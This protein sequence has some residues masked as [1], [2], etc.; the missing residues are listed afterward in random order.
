[1]IQKIRKITEDRNFNKLFETSTEIDGDQ[2]MPM[3]SCT[4]MLLYEMKSLK[5][6]QL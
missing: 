2:Q 5:E 4:M 6:K 1:M 3:Q